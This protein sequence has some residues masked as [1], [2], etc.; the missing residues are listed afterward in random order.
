MGMITI[1]YV[2]TVAIVKLDRGVTNALNLDL[3]REMDGFLEEARWDRGICGLVLGSTSEKFF[4]IGF[5]IKAMYDLPRKDFEVYFKAFNRMCLSLYTLP[6]P[7][8]AALTGHAIAGGCIMALC[9]DYR[10]MGEGKILMGLNEIRLGVPVPYPADCILRDIVGTRAAREITDVGAFHGPG[11]A[12]QTGLIDKVYPMGEVLD[13]SV[14]TVRA[15]GSW[16]PGAFAVIKHNRTA[17]VE[18]RIRTGW[19]ERE[20][21]FLDCWYSA[22]A[23]GLLREAMKKF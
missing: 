9:C 5:D 22:E 11:Q 13:R 10:F 8:V 2:N 4:S 16:P 18:R 23:R 1:D 12:I 3:V 7:T 20:Q 21:S 14:E 19:D 6:K 17:E 15:I